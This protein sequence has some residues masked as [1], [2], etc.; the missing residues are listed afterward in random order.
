MALKLPNAFCIRLNKG[1]ID[2]GQLFQP[3]INVDCK[4]TKPTCLAPEL[5]G[6]VRTFQLLQN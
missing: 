4:P 6:T 3:F 2:H 1:T 5:D